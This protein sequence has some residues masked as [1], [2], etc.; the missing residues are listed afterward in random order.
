MDHLGNKKNMSFVINKNH[1]V[2]VKLDNF[3]YDE[4]T[5]TIIVK[6]EKEFSQELQLGAGDT[7]PKEN[8]R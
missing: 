1:T 2:H 3:T 6:N 8:P 7:Q 4:K 5:D